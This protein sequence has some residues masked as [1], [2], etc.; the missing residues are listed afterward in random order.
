MANPSINKILNV[1]DRGFSADLSAKLNNLSLA[2]V[3]KESGYYS[4]LEIP[5]GK[6]IFPEDSGG[7]EPLRKYFEIAALRNAAGTQQIEHGLY[8]A[9][10]A[11]FTKMV[12]IYGTA[13]KMTAP[14]KCITLP[15]IS[16]TAI[17]IVELFVDAQ[18]INIVVGKDMS[19]YSAEICLEYLV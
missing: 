6:T 17:D 19:A 10:N 3:I 11:T 16:A 13:N 14:V 12:R 18:Y 2:M 8:L 7:V 15:H 5:T 4:S 9:P 1:K